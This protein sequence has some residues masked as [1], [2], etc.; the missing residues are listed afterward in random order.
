MEQLSRFLM[1]S[2]WCCWLAGYCSGPYFVVGFAAD[3]VVNLTSTSTCAWFVSSCVSL[4][5]GL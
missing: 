1:P 3:F 4:P 2:I 5:A